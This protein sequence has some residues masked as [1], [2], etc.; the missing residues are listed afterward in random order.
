MCSAYRGKK[1][2]SYS[3]ELELQTVVTHP[4]GAGNK[5]RIPWKSN[6]CS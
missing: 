3:L 1:R 2:S 4:V 5:T 6:K